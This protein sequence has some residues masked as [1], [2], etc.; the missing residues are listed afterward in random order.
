MHLLSPSVE[1]LDK[2]NDSQWVNE[3]LTAL[4]TDDNSLQRYTF[5]FIRVLVYDGGI[6]DDC[7]ICRN[8]ICLLKNVLCG[9]FA[10]VLLKWMI[11]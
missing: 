8:M 10:E 5:T 9:W 6:R 7:F 4:D 11:R 2:T 3:M 1:S